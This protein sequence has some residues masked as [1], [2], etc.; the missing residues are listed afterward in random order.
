M[1][2]PG[3]AAQKAQPSLAGTWKWNSEK[4]AAEQ[5]DQSADPTVRGGYRSG[6]RPRVGTG[7]TDVS[8]GSAAS[9][10]MGGDAGAAR[11]NLGPLG[12]YARPLPELVIVQTD[13]SITISDPRG[14]PRTYRPDGRKEVEPL[15][16]SESLE[17]VTKWKDAKLTTERRLGSLGVVR[18]VLWLDARANVLII[19]T[20]LSGPQLTQPVELR[21]IYDPAPGS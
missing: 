10:R 18:Q 17:I 19:E 12:L 2:A 3:A 9:G 16:G 21:W 4:T 14:T 8:G 20:R 6:G 7:V 1:S 5:L 15:L 13:S 11:G